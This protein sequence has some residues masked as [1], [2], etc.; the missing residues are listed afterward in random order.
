MWLSLILTVFITLEIVMFIKLWIID[1][2]TII[3][4]I[5][6]TLHTVLVSI[7]HSTNLFDFERMQTKVCRDRN[8]VGLIPPHGEISRDSPGTT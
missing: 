3:S 2:K 7:I 8:E 6:R 1:G 5:C 4:P